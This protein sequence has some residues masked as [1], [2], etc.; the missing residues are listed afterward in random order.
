MRKFWI[1]N[2]SGERRGLNNEAGVWFDSPEGLGVSA[3]D[4][5]YHVG[6]GVFAAC[7]GADK[8][9]ESIVGDLIFMSGAM[10]EGGYAQYGQFV[11]WLLSAR[12]LTLL[13]S[14]GGH[15]DTAWQRAVAVTSLSKGEEHAGALRCPVTFTPLEPWY[16]SAALAQK[17]TAD[18][19]TALVINP[20]V[21]SE[22]DAA[23]RLEYTGGISYPKLYVYG[24]DGEE[25]GRCEVHYSNI[26][27]DETLVI[28]ARR[29][30]PGVW[31]EDTEG[32][33]T[34]LMQWVNLSYEPWPLLPPGIGA[35]L[36]LTSEDTTIGAATLRVYDVR[37]TI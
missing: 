9:P 7:G 11:H 16:F 37:R 12:S 24:S 17:M 5:F 2:E 14:P 25:L 3:N 23:W 15:E 31:K 4:E 10:Y 8:T 36:K 22:T 33:R 1:E 20:T 35:Q 19:S 26:A 21:D 28:D 32:A 27:A 30:A 18:G 34:D 6:G 29:A 13:Y